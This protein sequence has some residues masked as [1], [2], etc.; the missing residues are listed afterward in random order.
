MILILAYLGFVSVGLPDG[1]H[2][3]AWP[4]MRADFDVPVGAVGF[5]LATDSAGGVDAKE[6]AGD[7]VDRVVEEFKELVE[8]NT[9]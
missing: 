7:T 8:R 5:I 1:A 2:G 6:V 9:E 3:V 4:Y